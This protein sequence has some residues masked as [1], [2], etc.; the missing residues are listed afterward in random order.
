MKSH[1]LMKKIGP[2]LLVIM[3]NILYACTVKFFLI[4]ADLISSG[5]TGI[6]LVVNHFTGLDM[7]VF[8]L[9]FNIF[10]LL[11][12]LLILGKKFALTT[13]MSSVLYPLFLSLLNNLVGDFRITDNTL[14]NVLFSGMGLGISLGTVLRQGASTGGMDIP[15]II[16]QK[17]FHIPVAVSLYVFDFIIILSQMSYHEPEDLLYGILLL[18]TTSITLDKMLVLGTSRSEV[19]IVSRYYE[20]IRLAILNELD[21]GVTIL[22][23]R[24]GYLGKNTEIVISVVSNREI[25]KIQKLVKDIDPEYFMTVTRVSEVIGRGFS[26]DKKYR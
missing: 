10:M 21:R 1:H 26:L 14:L 8:I 7:S 16:L 23:G 4:P 13:I 25:Y 22:Y 17:F 20:Q 6:S 15:P 12:A 11:I 3:G 18:M 24:S 5:T 9:C 2:V 19:K